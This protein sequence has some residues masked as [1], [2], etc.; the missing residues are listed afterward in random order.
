MGA[1]YQRGTLLFNQKRY[2]MAADEFRKELAQSPNDAGAMAMRALSLCYEGQPQEALAQAKAAVAADPER[3]FVH[4][5]LAGVMIG[6]PTCWTGKSLFGTL[7]LLARALPYRRRL[8]RARRPAMEAIRL[9]PRNADFLAMM[10]AIELDLS[11]P[12]D[13]LEWAGKGLAVRANHV[14]CANLRAR[15]LAK[16]GRPAE[17]RQA[18]SG[19]LAL[20]PNSAATHC[21]GGWTHLTVGDPHQAVKHFEESVRLNPNNASA[22]RGLGAARR[23]AAAGRSLSGVGILYFVVYMMI[24]AAFHDPSS[25]LPDQVALIGAASVIVVVIGWVAIGRI[26]GRRSKRP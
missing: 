23:A 9:E 11:R 24:R 21:D 4:Y 15:A 14:R 8:R 20:D 26:R 2:A 25:E 22:H 18:L 12:W 5:A 17:A 1:A 16:L 13:A 6:P 3:A 19:A 7:R 10:S